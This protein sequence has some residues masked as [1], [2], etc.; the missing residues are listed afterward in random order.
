MASFTSA[1]IVFENKYQAFVLQDVPP[2]AKPIELLAALNLPDFRGV[3]TLV[4]A[5]GSMPPD[6]IDAS[7]E[8]FTKGLAPV[9]EKLR[10]I[11]V[12]GATRFGGVLA[13]GDARN[14]I[15]G[16]FPLI[17]VV[18][19]GLVKIP[20]DLD[21]FHSHFVLVKGDNWGDESQILPGFLNATDKPGAVIV[22]NCRLTSAYME[23]EFP[24]HVRWA[25][26][27]IPIGNSG[28]VA[29]VLLDSESD[30]V[31]SLP[32]DAV[33]RGVDLHK[34]EALVALLEE[35]FAPA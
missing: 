3:I 35:L 26:V 31:K 4:L 17:G 16:T 15:G 9:A 5:M 10:L 6:I 22:I 25:D 28:G 12:D 14:A 8:L 23:G 13:M 20:D 11:V 33:I 32:A 21:P 29:D 30:L 34:P 1:T 2:D 27:I 18:P 7:R 24:H 19:Q